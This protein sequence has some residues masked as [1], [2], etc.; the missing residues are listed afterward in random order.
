MLKHIINSIVFGLTYV[1]AAL[2]F[3]KNRPSGKR[4]VWRESIARF[5]ITSLVHFLICLVFDAV[6]PGRETGENNLEL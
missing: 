4:P 2:F 3:H 6:L 5:F 1:L